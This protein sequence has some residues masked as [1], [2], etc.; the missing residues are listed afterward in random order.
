MKL[1]VKKS[2]VKVGKRRR[3]KTRSLDIENIDGDVCLKFIEENE[4]P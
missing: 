4:D 1:G 2:S 3:R